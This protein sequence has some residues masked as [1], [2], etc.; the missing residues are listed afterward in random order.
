M[1]NGSIVFM[2]LEALIPL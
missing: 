2:L 1:L